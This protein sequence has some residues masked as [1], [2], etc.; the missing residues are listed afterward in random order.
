MAPFD[1]RGAKP[2]GDLEEVVPRRLREQQGHQR[3]LLAEVA[4]GDDAQGSKHL[5]SHL[6]YARNLQHQDKSHN[7]FWI[8][9]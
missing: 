9:R 1:V 2:Q 6:P 4:T 8:Q 5:L 3:H 7:T